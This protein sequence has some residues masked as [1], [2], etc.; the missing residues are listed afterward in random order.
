MAE[1][2]STPGVLGGKPRIEG[3]RIGVLHVVDQIQG[4][5][6]PEEMTTQFDLTLGEV[7]TALAYYHEHPEEMRELREEIA[8]KIREHREDAIAGPEDLSEEVQ[9]GGEPSQRP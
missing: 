1:I 8:E 3:R 7:Y 2:V 9:S 4:G 5:R 6:T